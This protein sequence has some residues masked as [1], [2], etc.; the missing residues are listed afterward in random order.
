LNTRFFVQ[1]MLQKSRI[2]IGKIENSQ[3][4]VEPAAAKE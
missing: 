1:K 4:V 2:K 3:S